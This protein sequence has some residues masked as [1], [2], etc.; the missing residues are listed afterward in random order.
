MH[1]LRG[2]YV[3]LLRLHPKAFRQRFAE[4]MLWIF[5]Q[6]AA[7]QGAGRLLLDALTSLAR[8]WL[9]RPEYPEEPLAAQSPHTVGGPTFHSLESSRPRTALLLQ[10]GMLSLAAFSLV[11]F[12][13]GRGGGSPPSLLFGVHFH[14]EG[15]LPVARSSIEPA[16]L[17]TEVKLGLPPEDSWRQLAKVYFG[18]ILVLGTLDADD[19][20]ILS[21]LEIANA[22][23]ALRRL[24]LDGDGVLSPREA[25]QRFGDAETVSGL[26]PEFIRQA[27]HGFMRLHPV[28][29]ALDADRDGAISAA[30]IGNSPEALRTLDG[31]VDGSLIA[32]EVL[33][34]PVVNEA[35]VYLSRL[36]TNRDGSIS[37]A[38]RSDV[39]NGEIRDL[40]ARADRNQDSIVDGKELANELRL[41]A[42]KQQALENAVRSAFGAAGDSP[43]LGH[44]DSQGSTTNDSRP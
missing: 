42:A 12:A 25:G 30:E 1:T 44:S 4:E 32:P 28:L 11:V 23:T 35:A 22:P 17:T 18:A 2:V 31:D 37:H 33:P 24:D 19:D 38:E 34:D 13:I 21:P 5:D 41:R 3:A 7:E 40:L 9:V 16:E 26:D 36:D 15:L 39:S 6:A 43:N 27:G 10:G 8:Q 14:R 20:L 29:A